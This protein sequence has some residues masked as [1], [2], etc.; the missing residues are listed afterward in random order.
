MKRWH[1]LRMI[2][3]FWFL[4]VG[5][6]LFGAP[7]PVSVEEV[8]GTW[9]LMREGKP[10]LIKGAGGHTNLELLKQC[11]ANSIRTW[12]VDAKTKEILDAAHEQDLTVTVGIWLAHLNHGANYEDRGLIE[13]Q[14]AE[15]RRAVEAY[16][17]HPAVLAWGLGNEMEVGDGGDTNVAL[18]RHINDLAK[19]VKELDPHHPTMTV[20]AEMGGQKVPS[21]EAHCPDLDILGVNAYGGAPSLM[22]RYRELGGTKP[23]VLTEFGPLGFWEV[24][25]NA[26]GAADEMKS[27]DKAKFY[28]SGYQGIAADAMGLGSYAFLWGNKQEATATW[29]GMLLPNGERTAAVDTM[30][31]LWGAPVPNRVPVIESLEWKGEA[32]LKP[33]QIVRPT[34]KA[35]D[36]EGDPLRVKWVLMNDA[37]DYGFGGYAQA[38]PAEY[39]DSFLKGDLSGAEFRMPDNGGY[40]RL[41]AYVFD[42]AGGAAVANL[43]LKIDAP[44]RP[45]A[46]PRAKLPL[47]VYGDS[48]AS[49]AYY[50]SGYMGEAGAIQMR[51]D[52]VDSPQEGAHCLE[53]NYSKGDGWGGVVWQDPANDWGDA[54]G[55]FDL[56][57]AK[58]MTFWARGA[59]GGEVVKF[60]FGLIGEDKPFHD[61][62]KLEMEVKLQSDWTK[63]GFNLSGQDLSR[64]KTPFA[65]VI[66][67]KGEPITFYLDGI[68]I[69]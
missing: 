24:G 31:Q 17:D 19:M 66:V 20:I 33:G 34:L 5:L 64:I 9:K 15:V 42:D 1:M 12:G 21:I 46:A 63:Y 7:V 16:K 50:P 69:R 43:S 3:S 48:A 37:L 14:T 13:R 41:Y 10:Y 54:P 49:P 35:K 40:Y 27:G 52:C 4:S 18:W 60:H 8:G 62:A 25:R 23:V 67:A 68:E 39:P 59:N 55:G 2:T 65:W 26:I 32:I 45:V 11:G 38:R 61:T 28:A 36:P 47:V 6:F 56:S 30:A 51:E 53:V 22:K 29:F 58:Q 57:G 44:Q